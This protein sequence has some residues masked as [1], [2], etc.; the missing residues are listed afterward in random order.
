[1]ASQECID[2][3][4]TYGLS[5]HP[6]N[7]EYKDGL[8]LE[9]DIWDTYKGESLSSLTDLFTRDAKGCFIVCDVTDEETIDAAE[10]WVE[11]VRQKTDY[12][13]LKIPIFLIG[14]KCDLLKGK[15]Y[16]LT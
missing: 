9:L 5:A 7:I 11:V 2:N 13:N 12:E 4:S 15:Y 6:K 8:V 1:M 16:W 10:R 3:S 14:N